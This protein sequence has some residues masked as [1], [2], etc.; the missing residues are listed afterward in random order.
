MFPAIMEPTAKVKSFNKG[1]WTS[2]FSLKTKNIHILSE[3]SICVV[4]VFTDGKFGIIL[5]METCI[6]LLE[7]T[8]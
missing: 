6:V 4:K 7:N 1:I 8:A 2:N 3:G 5:F